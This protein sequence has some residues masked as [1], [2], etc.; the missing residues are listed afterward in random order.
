MLRH[1][2]GQ[3]LILRLDLLLQMRDSFLFGFVPVHNGWSVLSAGKPP[4]R[5]RRTPSAGGRTLSAEVPARH[6]DPRSALLPP[7]AAS[8]WRP[9]L[10]AC[11]AS[12]ASSCSL[13]YLNGPT[14]SP[15]PA[16]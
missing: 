4:L 15:F 9:S 7:N 2:F 13:R 8:E 1:Q 11:S 16:E 12:V 3:N 5:S 10:P 14:L 6:R